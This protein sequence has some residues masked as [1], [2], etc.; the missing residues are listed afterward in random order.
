MIGQETTGRRGLAFAL[1][2]VPV[3][4]TIAEIVAERA[5]SALFINFTNPAGLVTEAIRRVLGDRASGSATRRRPL[6]PGRGGARPARDDLWFD[7]FGINHLGWLRGVLDRGRDLLPDLLVDDE[8]AG[9]VRGGP[10]VRR[11]A[12]C[13]P[14]G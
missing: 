6:P 3:V 10:A 12:G 5:P 8:R 9:V 4:T 2:T 13:A 11:R 14:W 1:R 7:Y